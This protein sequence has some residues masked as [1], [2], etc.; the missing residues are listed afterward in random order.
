MWQKGAIFEYLEELSTLEK[1][2]EKNTLL[3]INMITK[4]KKN[5]Q[6]IKI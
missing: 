5:I 4:S 1:E 3:K 6:S 2:I